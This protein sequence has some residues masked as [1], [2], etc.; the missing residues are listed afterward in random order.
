M[1]KRNRSPQR[2]EQILDRA[3]R[4]QAFRPSVLDR[5]LFDTKIRTPGHAKAPW[6]NNRLDP[7]QLVARGAQDVPLSKIRSEQTTVSLKGVKEKLRNPGG[8]SSS[9]IPQAI[10]DPRTG[11]YWVNDGN[12]R[13]TAARA[14]GQK[15]IRVAVGEIVPSGPRPAQ[16]RPVMPPPVAPDAP[17]PRST[18][19]LKAG[20]LAAVAAPVVSGVNA[21]TR[22]REAGADMRAA[23]RQSVTA[24]G[25][26]AAVSAALAATVRAAVATAPRLLPMLGPVGVAALGGSMAYGG[27]EGYRKS[28][29]LVG[30]MRGAVGLDVSPRAPGLEQPRPDT[31]GLEAALRQGV[32]RDA[33]HRAAP[34]GGDT[35]TYVRKRDGQAITTTAE[36]AEQYRRQQR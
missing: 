8:K 12:H 24:T 33:P 10:F 11:T 35:V 26:T 34:D 3:A 18:A 16:T 21:F 14:L 20:A 2:A 36:K 13:V 5:D 31:S 30:A 17:K 28:G 15:S 22:A 1:A 7:R 4:M 19:A 23:A 27:Y 6:H 32:A 25:E 9:K 29:D